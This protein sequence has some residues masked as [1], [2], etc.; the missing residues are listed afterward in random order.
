MSKR[1]TPEI[2]TELA[3][4]E[5]F[6]FGSNQAGIH[7]AGAARVALDDFGAKWGVGE[8]L[9]G[10][11]YAFPTKDRQIQTLP[12]KTIKKAIAHFIVCCHKH[13]EKTFLLTKVGCGLAGLKIEQVAEAFKEFAPLQSNIVLPK[14]FDAIIYA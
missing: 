9:T 10:S 1:F 8:G 12:I 2:I 13:P 4:N 6:V 7:G 14:E 3:P 11:C 5:V